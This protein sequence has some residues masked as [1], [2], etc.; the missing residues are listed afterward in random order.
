MIYVCPIFYEPDVPYDEIDV[1]RSSTLPISWFI[2]LIEVKINL[3]D[4]DFALFHPWTI[5]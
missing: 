4:R 1:I 3:G 5:E 2:Q